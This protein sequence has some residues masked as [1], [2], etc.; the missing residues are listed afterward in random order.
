M[1][2]EQNIQRS[3]NLMH[4]GLSGCKAKKL[5]P[6]SIPKWVSLILTALEDLGLHGLCL[7]GFLK[8]QAKKTPKQHNV[9]K[10]QQKERPHGEEGG[11]LSRTCWRKG[12]EHAVYSGSHVSSGENRD[13][14][15]AGDDLIL[16][17][18]Q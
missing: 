8:T 5:D 13:G 11:R 9:I 15:A 18:H 1:A 6:C 16:A 10:P 14:A 17:G 12:G 4:L 7:G 2:M 3:G